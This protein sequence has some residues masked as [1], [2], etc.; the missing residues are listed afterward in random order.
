MRI[1]PRLASSCPDL[2]IPK[3]LTRAELKGKLTYRER[4]IIQRNRAKC[5][6]RD[7]FCRIGY[8]GEIAIAL[9]GECYGGSEWHHFVKRSMTRNMPPEDRHSTEVSGKVC[10]THHRMLEAHEIDY[11]FL[12]EDRADGPMKF[13]N[14]IGELVEHEMP[15]P[16][17]S[18]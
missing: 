6:R 10:A 12:T 14:E 1:R 17:W 5:D 4:Q 9:F 2:A 16:Q 13:S 11:D 3:G 18:R 15:K 7:G 8:W